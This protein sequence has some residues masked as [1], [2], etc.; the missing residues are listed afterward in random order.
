MWS[1]ND[2]REI[3]RVKRNATIVSFAMSRDGKL[4]AISHSSGCVSLVDC[5][6]G[7]TTLAEATLE[8]VSGLVRF[9]ED[10]QFLYCGRAFSSGKG[11]IRHLGV[12]VDAQRYFSLDVTDFPL[13]A[14]E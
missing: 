3:T 13:K 14:L 7:F 4:L 2:G 10:S 5:E 11:M 8:F 12:S 1:L 6:N 9:T